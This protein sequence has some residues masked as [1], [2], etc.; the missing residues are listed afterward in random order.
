MEVVFINSILDGG[1]M[2]LGSFVLFLHQL[3]RGFGRRGFIIDRSGHD[4]G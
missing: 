1:V 2:F 4:C 3:G